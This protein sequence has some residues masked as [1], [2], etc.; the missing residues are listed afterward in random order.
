MMTQVTRSWD[1]MGFCTTCPTKHHMMEPEIVHIVLSDQHAPA[2]L[3]GGPVCVGS[4]RVMNLGMNDLCRFILEPSLDMIRTD[5]NTEHIAFGLITLIKE[6]VKAE[7]PLILGVTSGTGEY[8]EGPLQYCAG[9]DRIMRWSNS[10]TLKVIHGKGRD[11]KS[12]IK[13]VFVAPATPHLDYEAYKLPVN[14]EGMKATVADLKREATGWG[15]TL[16]VVHSRHNHQCVNENIYTQKVDVVDPMYLAMRENTEF[17]YLHGLTDY[18]PND[19]FTTQNP[20]KFTL[21]ASKPIAPHPARSHLSTTG[22]RGLRPG[23]VAAYAASLIPALLT[24]GDSEHKGINLI[25]QHTLAVRANH[26]NLVMEEEEWQQFL[27]SANDRPDADDMLCVH[28]GA[29]PEAKVYKTLEALNNHLKTCYPG[30]NP[31]V[32]GQCELGVQ[33]HQ[34]E[35]SVD[36]NKKIKTI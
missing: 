35:K 22:S 15:R 26:H 34:A 20:S 8:L 33:D 10:R 36:E 2:I 7:K 1:T 11:V 3:P 21:G 30:M 31:M 24:A 23:Y 29:H 5:Q 13:T 17:H 16:T 14:P 27:F 9:M 25:T 32:K 4:Y 12:V 19:V 18:N 28:R 6:C